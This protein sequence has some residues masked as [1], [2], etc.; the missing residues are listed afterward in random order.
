MRR[1]EREGEHS[2]DADFLCRNARFSRVATSRGPCMRRGCKTLRR[3]ARSHSIRVSRG[4]KASQGL[5][6]A[7]LGGQKYLPHRTLRHLANHLLLLRL[8][9]LLLLVFRQR[10]QWLRGGS[11]LRLA[12]SGVK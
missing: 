4:L 5:E 6:E 1:E 7:L 3:T 2:A 8:R 9:L 10:L 11:P 12:P